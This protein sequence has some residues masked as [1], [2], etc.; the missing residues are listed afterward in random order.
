[1]KKTTF[2]NLLLLT[3]TTIFTACSSKDVKPKNRAELFQI[4]QEQIAQL[5]MATTYPID[6]RP[7]ILQNNYNTS[8]YEIQQIHVINTPTSARRYS[9]YQR[10]QHFQPQPQHIA[11]TN[12]RRNNF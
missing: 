1:M 7:P 12:Y 3:T 4:E 9:N 10:N 8:H 11:Y 2:I 6:R 5:P